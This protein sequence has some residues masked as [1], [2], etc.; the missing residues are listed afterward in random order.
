MADRTRHAAHQR[1]VCATIAACA[2]PHP[3]PEPAKRHRENSTALR[4]GAGQYDGVA[5]LLWDDVKCYF[6][7]DLMGSLP[8]V[9]VPD[10]SGNDWQDLLDLVVE[11]GW[12]CQYSEGESVLPLPRAEAALSPAADTECPSLR[13]WLSAD[14]LAIFRF[15]SDEEID[16]DVDL[17]E[18]QGQERL[19]MFCGF[20]QEIGR[21]LGKPVLMHPEGAHGR[22]V[23]GFDVDAD[24]VV[25]LAESRSGDGG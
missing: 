24:R 14:V 11:K 8:D 9:T 1:E 6:D 25:L 7:P 5:D 19:E 2:R 12:K 23:L 4:S 20:L 10:A 21:R 18:L 22:P 17:S 15:S 3:D 16:F 13:V